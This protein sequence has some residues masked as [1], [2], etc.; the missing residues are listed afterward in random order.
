MLCRDLAGL[1]TLGL[2]IK[3]QRGIGRQIV[4]CKAEAKRG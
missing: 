2:E 3:N 1:K 4:P